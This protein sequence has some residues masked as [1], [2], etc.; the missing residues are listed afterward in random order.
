MLPSIAFPSPGGEHT[1]S[2]SGLYTQ[3]YERELHAETFKDYEHIRGVPSKHGLTTAAFDTDTSTDSYDILV[4]GY[5]PET[6]SSIAKAVNESANALKNRHPTISLQHLQTVVIGADHQEALNFCREAARPFDENFVQHVAHAWGCCFP[7]E[8]G[9]VAIVHTSVIAAALSADPP[10]IASGKRVI[11]HELCHAH[12]VGKRRAWLLRWAKEPASYHRAY[13]DC[14]NLWAEYFANRFAYF[15]GDEP[16]SD[17][18]R[19]SQV[20]QHLHTLP[21]APATR[22]LCAA[23]GYALGTLHGM[24]QPLPAVAPQLQR[25]IQS[26]GLLQAWNMT[27]AALP[28]MLSTGAAWDSE[29][30]ILYAADMVRSI[31]QCCERVCTQ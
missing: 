2:L 4:M 6:R 3:L 9:I 7:T 14:Q 16:Y 31:E 13:G 15:V 23:M 10:F 12:D 28:K 30:G 1:N 29:N 20:L 22:A 18:L 17:I 8:H 24:D 25:Q 26:M 11:R 27:D 21:R 5:P 19:L